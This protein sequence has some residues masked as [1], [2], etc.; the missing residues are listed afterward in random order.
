V[1]IIPMLNPPAL[2]AA[3]R[4]SPIDGLDMNRCYPGDASGSVT[5]VITNFISSVVLPEAEVVV[6]LHTGGTGAVYMPSALMHPLAEG[7]LMADTLKAVRAFRAPAGV[8]IDESD[9]PD[10]F[11]TFAESLGKIFI[12][13][14]LGGGG[15]AR[16]TIAVAEAGIYNTLI[17][18]GIRAGTPVV[19]EWRGRRESRLFE[20]PDLQHIASA[21]ANGLYEPLVELGEEVVTA[22]ALGLI[23]PIDDPWGDPVA[24]TAPKA[25]VLLMRR[26]SGRIDE[27]QR[28]AVIGRAHPDSGR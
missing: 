4:R 23:Y 3:Q 22:Q 2:R 13:A 16:E 18:F 25:G 5:Q 14:E 6:D 26:A 21:T 27:G 28:A 15:V 10:M 1:I 8:V 17:H 7:T 19:P 9:K 11:D 12:F 24:V 20:V